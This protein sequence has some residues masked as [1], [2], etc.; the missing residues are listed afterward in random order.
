MTPFDLRALLHKIEVTEGTDATPTPDTNAILLL[1]GSG[2]INVDELERNIDQPAGGAKP[3]V[4]ARKHAVITG[5]VELV[6]AATEGTA[7]PIGDLLRNAG[8]TQVLG[9]APDNAIYT[10]TLTGIP[11]A[12]AWFYHGGEVL[13][14]VGARARLTSINMSIN[15]FPRAGVEIMGKIGALDEAAMPSGANAPDTSAFQVP[16][17]GTDANMTIELGGF[18]LDGISLELDPGVALAMLYHTEATLSRQSA[19]AVTGTLRCYRP[20]R[21]DINIRQLAAAAQTAPLLVDYVTGDDERDLFL[22][23]PAVQIGEPVRADLDG[24]VVWD[25][26]LRLLPDAGNDD[27]TLGFGPRT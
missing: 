18:A 7:P 20:A 5:D 13:K 19:R 11:S 17:V 27:Y 21:S 22:T 4:Q 25:I 10:P 26:P 23:A 9:E 14:M 3:Y 16:I 15:D 8:H 24:L 12:S 1:D 2:Q 6:G